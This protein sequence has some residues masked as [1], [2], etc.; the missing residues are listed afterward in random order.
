MLKSIADALNVST[1][2][3]MAQAGLVT[4]DGLQEGPSTEAAIRMDSRLT[5]AQKRAMLSVYRSYIEDNIEDDS[6]SPESA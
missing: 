2:T 3:I 6:K 4:G 1:E 5:E